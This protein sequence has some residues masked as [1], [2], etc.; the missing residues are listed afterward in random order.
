MVAMNEATS[1]LRWHQRMS[2]S[3]YGALIDCIVIAR[4]FYLLSW[5]S[6][7]FASQESQILES[8]IDTELVA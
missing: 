2:R 7:V 4:K 1:R 8:E 6:Q 3:G 5:R